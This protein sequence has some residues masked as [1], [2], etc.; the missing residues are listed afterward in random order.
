[1]ERVLA[2]DLGTRRSGLAVNPTGNRLIL[3]LATI[4]HGT[5]EELA[6][7]L[8]AIIHE[9]DVERVVLGAPGRSIHGDAS[10]RV[11]ALSHLLP[12][13][14]SIQH[15]QLTT[16]EAERQLASE[17]QAGRSAGR[18]GDSDARAARLILEEYL[19]T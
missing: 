18:Q 12:V 19:G 13:P 17:G 1:M 15:E 11:S 10:L 9:Y 3:E 4:A 7:A 6:V 5:V 16:K 14:V 2:V 8:S